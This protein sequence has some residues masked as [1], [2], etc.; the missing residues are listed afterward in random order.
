M[1][2]KFIYICV[3]TIVQTLTK[4]VKIYKKLIFYIFFLR[5]FCV[6]HFFVVLLQPL[7]RSDA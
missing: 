5:F 4:T 7:L 3:L 2:K 6:F 1:P